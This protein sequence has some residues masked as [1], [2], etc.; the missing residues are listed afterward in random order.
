MKV[1]EIVFS[2]VGREIYSGL[3]IMI[4]CQQDV[5]TLDNECTKDRFRIIYIKEGHGFFRNGDCSQIITSP[6]IL[7]LNEN[8]HVD[9]EDTVDLK[10]DIIYFNPC[11]VYST[12]AYENIE[13]WRNI[14]DNDKYFYRPFLRRDESYIG[15]FSTNYYLGNRVSQLISR[16]DKELA[17]Q[18]DH[19]WPCRS[20]SYYIELL[21]LVNSIYD[22]DYIPDNIYVGKM[23]DEIRDIIN[24]LHVHYEDKIVI[25]DITKHFHTNKTT[26]NKKFKAVMG[27]TV[28]EYM[29]SL[30]MQVACSFLRKTT[31]SVKEITERAGYRDDSHFLRSFKKY[32]G[33]TPSEYREQYDAM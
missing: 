8:D 24:W 7:C 28:M 18:R 3:E 4:C 19:Y 26:L 11:G 14:S 29:I 17:A 33:C 10:M 16:V 23:T 25:E 5:E 6:M 15:A 9:L 13:K 31:L 1:K 27:I 32:T 12:I 2:T 21:L 22:E 20:R 30:R